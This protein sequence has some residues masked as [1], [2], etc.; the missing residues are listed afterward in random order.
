MAAL[1]AAVL[2]AGCGGSDSVAQVGS[3]TIGKTDLADAV[4]HFEQEAQSEGRPFPDAGSS[5][6]RTVER[7]ALALLVYRSEL[8]QS[9]KKLGVGVS[10][11]EVES[12]LAGASAE[13]DESGRFARDTVRAQIAY[14]HIYDKVTGSV[15][16][17]K[18]GDTISRWLARMKS[19]YAVSYEDGFG[20]TA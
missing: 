11:S 6:Y 3:A 10:E 1:A 15:P 20:P 12:R 7:Q 2:A 9:A 5:G 13:A 8:L 17:A 14:E 4:D 18:R 16:A 19:S